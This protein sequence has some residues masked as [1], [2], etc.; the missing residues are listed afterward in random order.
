MGMMF[1][2]LAAAAAALLLMPGAARAEWRAVETQ[3][4]IIYTQSDD[5]DALRLA[6]RLETVDG[7]MRLA[8]NISD[9]VEPV[10]VRIYEVG[11]N[12][13]VAAALGE[14]DSP[15]AG[16][17][18]SNIL[19]P[20]AVTPHS[21]T[22]HAGDFSP[23]LVLHHEYAHHFML[24]YF[25]AT[26]PQWYVEGYAELIG[27]SKIQ[28]DGKI[29]YGYPAKHRGHDIAAEWMPLDELFLTPPE[30]LRDYDVY[31]QG[32]AMAHFF[33]FN[34][35]RAAQ[36]RAYLH[37]LSVGRSPAEAAKVFGDLKALNREARTYVLNGVFDYKL[38][39][40][41][42][43]QPVIEAT[44][45]VSPGEAAMIPAVIAFRDDELSFYRKAG[46]REHEKHLRDANL[47]KAHDIA[48]R[49]PGD[50]F[51]HAFVAVAEYSAGNYTAGEAAADRA[52]ALDGN[53]L[54]ALVVKSLSLAH[55]AGVLSGPARAAKE[56]EARQLAVRAQKADQNDPLPL[57]A[58]YESYHL[59]G[60]T[61][62]RQAVDLL[63]GAVETMPDNT[64][65]RQAL[66][67]E[68][69]AE[70]NWAEAIHYL[71][72][73]AN[74]PHESPRRAAAKEQLAKLLAELRKERGLPAA[75]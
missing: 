72:P 28:P 22:F 24:Q 74:D 25:P 52:L 64:V 18:T 59:A 14:Y 33:T 31:G 13:E 60:D 41:P 32:W 5:K 30:K 26:Y 16:F 1:R 44:R 54:R 58:F 21:T 37:A 75:S 20:F 61:P 40:V 2:K 15:V 6:T 49:V 12:G 43:A 7:L 45:P 10:K 36:L 47:E 65:M 29:A 38:V 27:S 4:F 48:R 66:V 8:S 57:F 35:E 70:K 55:Q 19:G 71:A 73:I 11:T 39:S 3:H 17:Y 68:L 46:D 63:A 23:E 67:D 62:T 42:I 50:P 51:V 9:N 56:Q 34:K 53:N 69:A